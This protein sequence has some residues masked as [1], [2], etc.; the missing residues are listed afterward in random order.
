M[1]KI[2][3]NVSDKFKNGVIKGNVKA[4]DIIT[5]LL[6]HKEIKKTSD[7]KTEFCCIADLT[8]NGKKIIGA[9]ISSVCSMYN[10]NGKIILEIK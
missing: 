2:E 5:E 7:L 8:C 9:S 1:E 6:K 3:F 10:G 4:K